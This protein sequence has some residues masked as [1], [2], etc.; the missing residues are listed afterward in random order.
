M[1]GTAQRFE[2]GKGASRAIAYGKNIPVNETIKCKGPEAGII[3]GVFVQLQGGQS[4][5]G[6]VIKSARFCRTL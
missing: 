5:I 3:P 4:K 1:G 6:E 2:G